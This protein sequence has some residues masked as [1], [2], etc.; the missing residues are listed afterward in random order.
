MSAKNSGVENV[1]TPETGCYLLFTS[2]T[3]GTP[4]GVLMS[5]RG[6]A[7]LVQWDL[8]FRRCEPGRVHLQFA[9]FHFDIAFHELFSAISSGGTAVLA[10]QEQRQDAGLLLELLSSSRIEKSYLPY[11]AQSVGIGSAC[12][13]RTALPHRR[14]HSWRAR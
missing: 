8:L 2:G 4:K 13:L 11:S 1:S 10:T 12:I 5:N 14:H 7:N 9:S 3:T 6:L